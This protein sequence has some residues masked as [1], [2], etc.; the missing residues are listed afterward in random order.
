[1]TVR[2]MICLGYLLGYVLSRN[3]HDLDEVA[4]RQYINYRVLPFSV[5]M[6]KCIFSNISS[7]MQKLLKA[8][9]NTFFENLSGCKSPSNGLFYCLW[10][11]HLT[12]SICRCESL[13]FPQ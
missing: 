8:H 5:G 3:E 9:L 12:N 2:W 1:M 6:Q 13:C 11:K 10:R 7:G 4:I